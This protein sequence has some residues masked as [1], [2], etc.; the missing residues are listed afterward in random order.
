M[1]GFLIHINLKLS[2]LDCVDAGLENLKIVSCDSNI[3]IKS[4][5]DEQIIIAQF[6]IILTLYFTGG[7]LGIEQFSA[8][9]GTATPFSA[10]S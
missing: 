1:P 3:A 2:V 9:N 10:E 7:V 8:T 4:L 5:S 6:L